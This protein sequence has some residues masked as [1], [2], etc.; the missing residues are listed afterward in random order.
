MTIPT[1]SITKSSSLALN[2]FIMN[3]KEDDRGDSDTH[4]HE[5]GNVQ[6]STQDYIQY[7]KS[8]NMEILSPD[9]K[10]FLR[11]NRIRVRNG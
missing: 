1:I 2:K 3:D 10:S 11:K 5:S 9:V 6:N 4:S 7:S 8:I